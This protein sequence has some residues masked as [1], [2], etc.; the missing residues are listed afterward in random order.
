MFCYV[1]LKICT[2]KYKY[3]S[4]FRLIWQ[5]HYIINNW[6]YMV[7]YSLVFF[8]IKLRVGNI[9][10]DVESN[11]FVKVDQIWQHI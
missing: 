8:Y 4:Y 2:I 1:V 6:V 9:F 11:I 5:A 7:M 10:K 3:F